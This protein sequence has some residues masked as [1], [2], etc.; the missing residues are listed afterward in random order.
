MFVPTGKDLFLEV[1]KIAALKQNSEFIWKLSGSY[2]I[3]KAYYD[4]RL[5]IRRRVERAEFSGYNLVL[6]NVQSNESGIY[7][8]NVY[9]TISKPIPEHVVTVFGES[10]IISNDNTLQYAAT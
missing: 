6:K 10:L 3:V 4:N 1:K 9:G 7:T 8:A 5:I 2:I